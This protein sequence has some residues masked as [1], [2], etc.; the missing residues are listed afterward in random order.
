MKIDCNV[1]SCKSL[2][3]ARRLYNRNGIGAFKFHNLLKN[4]IDLE[5]GY[6]PRYIE[7]FMDNYKDDNFLIDAHRKGSDNEFGL[8]RNHIEKDIVDLSCR[9][10][11]SSRE[12]HTNQYTSIDFHMRRARQ[13]YRYL[14]DR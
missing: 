7:L 11:C 14:A 9:M 8:S 13:K 3:T 5:Y 2:K 6:I 12:G 10:N 1:Y 4:Q